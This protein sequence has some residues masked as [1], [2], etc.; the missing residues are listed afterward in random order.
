MFLD[1]EHL[2]LKQWGQL[3]IRK[4]IINTLKSVQKVWKYKEN[5]TFIELFQL[6]SEPIALNL[7]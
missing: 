6:T 1:G 3:L 5:G 7:E 4:R 2:H